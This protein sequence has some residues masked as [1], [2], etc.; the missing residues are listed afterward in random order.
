MGSDFATDH[1]RC[2]SVVQW[3]GKNLTVEICGEILSKTSPP[4]DVKLQIPADE[5]I[6]VKYGRKRTKRGGKHHFKVCF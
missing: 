3:D 6:W 5:H 2:F 1:W 4:V